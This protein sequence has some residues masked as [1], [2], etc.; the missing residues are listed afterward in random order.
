LNGSANASI[1]S[2]LESPAVSSSKCPC[3]VRLAD[4]A[5][6]EVSFTCPTQKTA[7]LFWGSPKL[8]WNANTRISYYQQGERNFITFDLSFASLRNNLREIDLTGKHLTGANLMLVEQC[9]LI[10]AICLRRADLRSAGWANLSVAIWSG[11]ANLLAKRICALLVWK[12]SPIGP[13][14]LPA[15]GGA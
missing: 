9:Q 6:I 5:P 14:C 15:D 12:Q 7:E 1:W 2:D 13:H 8:K 10:G 4:P 3:A 11:R